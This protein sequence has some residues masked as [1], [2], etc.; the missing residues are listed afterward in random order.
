MFKRNKLLI[1]ENIQDYS[2]KALST[3]HR[4]KHK[5]S[6]NEEK[7][8]L[9]DIKRN[10]VREKYLSKI[11]DIEETAQLNKDRL[12]ELEKVESETMQKLKNTAIMH[13]YI[14]SRFQDAFWPGL[15]ITPSIAPNSYRASN[16][17]FDFEKEI[18]QRN[19]DDIDIQKMPNISPLSH[20]NSR[21]YLGL[22]GKANRTF[23]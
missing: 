1:E 8:I 13:D 9:R 14:Q 12:K 16:K 6:I 5:R 2:R 19:F 11:H 4:L 20:N 15:H 17:L 18:N 21:G 7:R 10:E 3:L 23:K 22:R